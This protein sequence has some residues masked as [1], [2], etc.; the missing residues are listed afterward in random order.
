MII[1]R[2][3]WK[4]KVG[5]RAEVI[6]LVKAV[7]EESGLT[8][9][10]CTFTYGRYYEMVTS[11]LEFETEEDQKKFWNDLDSSQPAWVEWQKKRPDLTESSRRELL[12][13]H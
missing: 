12:R 7:V 6:E 5:C 1:E 2:W 3:T 9:R 10:V 13:V 8:P 4:V 11:D